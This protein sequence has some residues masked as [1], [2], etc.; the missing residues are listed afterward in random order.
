MSLP[1]LQIYLLPHVTL[2]FDLQTPKVDGFMPLLRGP[3]VPIGINICSLIFN[4]SC[5][6]TN[7]WTDKLTDE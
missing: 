1:G 5:S 2:I 7:V 4:I 6:Q 3:F